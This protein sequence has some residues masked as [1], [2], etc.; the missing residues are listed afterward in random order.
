MSRVPSFRHRSCLASTRSSGRSAGWP[1]PPRRAI[2]P[3]ISSASSVARRAGTSPDHPCGGGIHPRTARDHAGGK[4]A[5]DPRAARRGTGAPFLHRGIAAR[6]FQRA[7]LLADGLEVLGADLPTACCRSISSVPKQNA[8]CARSISW[9]GTDENVIG[10]RLASP[11]S[12]RSKEGAMNNPTKTTATTTFMP[13]ASQ[14]SLETM[15]VQALANLG[16]GHIAYVR[17]DQVRRTVPA[18]PA[19]ARLS[20]GP[21]LF[22][23]LGR[24]RHADHGDRQPK[25]RDR[26]RLG[27]RPDARQRALSGCRLSPAPMGA[28]TVR[29]LDTATGGRAQPW[30]SRQ[31]RIAGVPRDWRAEAAPQDEVVDAS[32][33]GL[34]S[35]P[36][37]MILRARQP[38]VAISMS[39]VT[40]RRPAVLDEL[41][42]CCH[43]TSGSSMPCRMCT[44]IRHRSAVR[45][46]GDAGG[47][48]R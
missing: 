38:M 17:A 21:D 22:A 18:F 42:A 8:S 28:R 39:V 29:A 45:P 10:A 43:G 30:T 16:E 20:P 32:D 35:Q 15:P 1:K 46:A 40:T 41:Q 4:P 23:L 25:H 7:F 33:R 5:R 24:R 27:A 48:P 47:R 44:G 14:A 37:S 11:T 2:R 9:R 19:G 3:T 26:Q 13:N 36:R 6:Q 34:P 12:L 31:P